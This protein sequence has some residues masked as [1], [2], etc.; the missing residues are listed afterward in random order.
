[1]SQGIMELARQW[2]KN[3]LFVDDSKPFPDLV[4]IYYQWI[5]GHSPEDNFTGDFKDDN[6]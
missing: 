4:L 2:F 5:P 3:G 6:P 1:M